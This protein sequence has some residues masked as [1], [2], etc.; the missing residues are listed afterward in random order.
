MNHRLNLFI[1]FSTSWI[2]THSVPKMD[3]EFSVFNISFPWF[4]VIGAGVVII[5][6][7]I[8]SHC[9]GGHDISK[10]GT[11]L[12][13][14]VAHW[15]VPTEIREVELRTISTK[16]NE[17]DDTTHWT[18]SSPEEAAEDNKKHGVMEIKN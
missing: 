13:S 6:G 2:S 18:W 7:S 17:E 9:T 12:I 3:P 15:L 11:K 1:S 10:T 16:P 14:P 4:S 8:V 5:V